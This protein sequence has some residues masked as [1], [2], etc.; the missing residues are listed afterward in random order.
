MLVCSFI[1]QYYNILSVSTDKMGG[2]YQEDSRLCISSPEGVSQSVGTEA[3]RDRFV[4]LGFS[5]ME[6]DIQSASFL[7]AHAGAILVVITG[8]MTLK[9][10]VSR[11][12]SQTILLV[13]SELNARFVVSSDVLA[14]V[15]GPDFAKE[16]E[17]V[18]TVKATPK[19]VNKV[20]SSQN[21]LAAD[22]KA[23]AETAPKSQKKA[24]KPAAPEG[25]ERV[26]ESGSSTDGQVE[27]KRR[28]KKKSAQEP[29]DVKT[30]AASV[31]GA[32]SKSPTSVVAKSVES[33][34]PV[35]GSQPVRSGE[36]EAVASNKANRGPEVPASY[37]QMLKSSSR[38]SSQQPAAK[39][40]PVDANKM[41][42][43]AGAENVNKKSET[44]ARKSFEAG[45]ALYVKDIDKECTVEKLTQVF[46]AFGQIASVE[47]PQN[48]KFA[49]VNF[50]TPAGVQTVLSQPQIVLD[51]KKLVCE[52]RTSSGS[53]GRS[54]GGK[55]GKPRASQPSE[56]K[57]NTSSNVKNS[58][59]AR[60]GDVA[61]G[62]TGK[63][64]A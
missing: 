9:G 61:A 42:G 63:K 22:P 32:K 51:G 41:N 48:K 18:K 6:I 36:N 56:G 26:D 43:K 3:I 46:K 59:G 21:Q 23:K 40:V 7:P 4:E 13:P 47:I 64:K 27:S 62:S 24:S 11:N 28:R 5:G 16:P 49:F 17:P 29:A 2:F 60:R 19:E 10:K 50:K 15:G 31:E 25:D 14:V 53:G 45:C 33:E 55:G 20:V 54:R 58:N 57:N 39:E 44:S 8:V 52:E 12:I 38:P 34:K 1:Q 30:R 37:A 35:Q